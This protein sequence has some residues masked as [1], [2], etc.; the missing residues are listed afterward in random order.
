MRL[1][2]GLY[3]SS[4]QSVGS[5]YDPAGLPLTGWW[6]AS[7]AGSPWTGTASA[8]SSGS[9]NLTEATNPPAAGT[10]VNG[11]TPAAFDG[12]NDRLANATAMSSIFTAAAGTFVVI[13]KTNAAAAP[14]AGPYDD[15]TFFSDPA[16]GAVGL[17][18]NTSG[19]RAFLTDGSYKTATIAQ[20]TGSWF[21]ACMRWDSAN[22]S[23]DINGGATTNVAAGA[24]SNVTGT[25]RI[26]A[27]Y[28]AAAFLNGSILEVMTA[29]SKLTDTDRNNIKS[30]FNARYALSL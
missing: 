10:A 22:L 4:L 6:R 24:I 20:G 7:Y 9:K 23:L 21:M 12:T 30:Y 3:L 29:A 2:L 1:G 14:A 25:L 26:G 17:G 28:A 13:A 11:L 19:V 16:I 18:W 5:S 27:N 8:G 15:P